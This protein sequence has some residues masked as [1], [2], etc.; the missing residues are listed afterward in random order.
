[1]DKKECYQDGASRLDIRYIDNSRPRESKSQKSQLVDHNL[2]NK[3]I[4]TP[5]ESKIE[6]DVK[7]SHRTNAT[8]NDIQHKI[9]SLLQNDTNLANYDIR[10]YCNQ[11]QAEITG[12]VDA[13]SEK[14]YAQKLVQ[15]H[16]NIPIINSISIS[17]DGHI[18]DKD[19]Y[20]EI[21]EELNLRNLGAENLSIDVSDGIVTIQGE[22]PENIKEIVNTIKTAR[23]VAAVQNYT[24]EEREPTLEDYFHS[25]VNNDKED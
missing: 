18:V 15:S 5:I 13:L 17:T 10:V 9:Q 7:K 12:I 3:D 20:Q 16:Y 19:V 6:G 1:M 23:G 21:V 24:S 4:K 22:R 25:Q 8:A 14:E 2:D 11:R